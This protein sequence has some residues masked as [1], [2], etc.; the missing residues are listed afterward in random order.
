MFKYNLKNFIFNKFQF[1]S[2]ATKMRAGVTK[3][4]KDSP[5]KRLGIKKF[6]GQEVRESQILVRQRGL[7]FKPGENVH[8]GR[9][10]TLH[11]SKEGKVTFT[12]DPW[13]PNKRV[14]Y[15]HVIEQEIPNRK[16]MAIIIIGIPTQA[17]HVSS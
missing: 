4:K 17:F 16:V 2:F 5:G 1:F 6:G 7:K 10:H 15:V 13:Y 9:D 14:R 3:N 12:T 8:Y 11:A